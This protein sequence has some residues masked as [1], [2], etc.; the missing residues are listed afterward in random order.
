MRDDFPKPHALLST[1]KVWKTTDVERWQK[2]HNA[3]FQVGRKPAKPT[4]R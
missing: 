3:P 2:K 4:K 1:G